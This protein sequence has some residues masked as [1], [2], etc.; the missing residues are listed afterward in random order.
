MIDRKYWK[1]ERACFRAVELT[2]EQKKFF[3]KWHKQGREY[4]KIRRSI[5]GDY[6]GQRIRD[7]RRYFKYENGAEWRAQYV[8]GGLSFS[9][10]GDTAREAINHVKLIIQ[11]ERR[12]L[13]RIENPLEPGRFLTR[14]N[15]K[16]SAVAFQQKRPKDN[17]QYIGVELEF[18][19]PVRGVELA[20]K[21]PREL[22]Q[23][24]EIKTDGSISGPG[25]GAEIAIL[26]PEGEIEGIIKSLTAALLSAGCTVNS[27]CGLHVHIDARTL[28]DADRLPT[29][30]RMRKAMTILSPLLPAD[31]KSN[32]YCRD[33]GRAPSFRDRYYK[34]N[35]AALNRHQTIE[36]RAHGGT[37]DAGKIIAWVKTW[38]GVMHSKAHLLRRRATLEK[39]LEVFGIAPDVIQYFKLRA[40]KMAEKPATTENEVLLGA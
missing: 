25:W 23:Y 39:N 31:R 40:Q 19:S 24:I 20:P 34:I 16:L 17:R 15:E 9:A 32:R 38:V 8:R 26:A 35:M 33:N 28:P 11:R 37:L 3:L 36:I 5:F 1:I 13:R 7:L 14:Q 18:L 29:Y 10:T 6:T 30:G 12:A 22:Y 21:I 27:S 4:S 2:P